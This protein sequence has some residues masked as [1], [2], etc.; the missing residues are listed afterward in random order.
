[1]KVGVVRKSNLV[2]NYDFDFKAEIEID[3]RDFMKR[4]WNQK[5]PNFEGF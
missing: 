4:F 5:S 1:M 2:I 3:L